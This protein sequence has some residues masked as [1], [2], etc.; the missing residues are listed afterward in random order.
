[1]PRKE[2][3]LTRAEQ[4]AIREMHQDIR[5][6]SRTRAAEKG[7]PMDVIVEN[8]NQTRDGKLTR[9]RHTGMPYG[10]RAKIVYPSERAAERVTA[11]SP[12]PMYTYLCPDARHWHTT[13]N[14]R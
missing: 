12:E 8:A 11:A 3:A 5:Q 7:L 4:R 6:V 1:M 10:H 14:P 2:R 13:S 9:C